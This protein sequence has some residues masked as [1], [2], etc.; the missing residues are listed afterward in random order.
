MTFLFNLVIFRFQ[1]LIF[2]AVHLNSL[3]G[4]RLVA[5]IFIK[6][7]FCW[8]RSPHDP[9][10]EVDGATTARGAVDEILATGL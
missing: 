1:P 6:T 2:R 3:P 8:H 9:P 4:P 5:T 10:S 7:Y